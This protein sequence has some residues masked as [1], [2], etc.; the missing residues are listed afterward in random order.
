ME[1]VAG[2]PAAIAV[3]LGYVRVTARIVPTI[4]S[5]LRTVISAIA[6]SLWS[7]ISLVFPPL[8]AFT[9]IVGS[10]AGMLAVAAGV[11]GYL[12]SVCYVFN[13]TFKT[14]TD[15]VSSGF[16]LASLISKVVGMIGAGVHTILD[17][18]NNVVSAAQNAVGQFAG[19]F[20]GGLFGDLFNAVDGLLDKLGDL[21][22]A[23]FGIAKSGKG[24]FA[25][26]GESL[27][28][29]M[30]NVVAGV[31]NTA[32]R[33][34]AFVKSAVAEIQGLFSLRCGFRA[35]QVEK[36]IAICSRSSS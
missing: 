21:L 11:F 28:E 6:Q 30:Q 20:G 31:Q 22:R 7:L 26:L 29:L 19:T 17:L 33:I 12:N 18:F 2:L 36:T 1:A 23:I 14:V 24:F 27:Q 3:T 9:P 25:D 13:K 32:Q 10:L 5:G 8:A 34:V 35:G 15:T 16:G 4:I